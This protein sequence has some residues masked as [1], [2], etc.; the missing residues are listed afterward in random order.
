MKDLTLFWRWLR[1]RTNLRRVHLA[2]GL[3][4]TVAAILA[5]VAAQFLGLPLLLW[6]VQTAVIAP[7]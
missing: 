3:W 5:L 6:A 1:S 4:V 2:L 7:P